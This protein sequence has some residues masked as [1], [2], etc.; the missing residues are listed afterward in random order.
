MTS[1][2]C[3]ALVNGVLNRPE[4]GK[5][6][7]R[8]HYPY[9]FFVFVLLIQKVEKK[10][11]NYGKHAVHDYVRL[12]LTKTPENNLCNRKKSLGEILM[13]IMYGCGCD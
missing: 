9:L 11:G 13:D 3:D 10:Q 4:R 8:L 7:I 5:S 12:L 2:G 6:R 1:C